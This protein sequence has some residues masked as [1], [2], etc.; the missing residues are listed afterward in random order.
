MMSPRAAWKPA[1]SAAALPKLRRKRMP[2]TSACCA[3]QLGDDLPGAVRAAV[4]HEDDFQIELLL[5]GHSGDLGVQRR[6][7]VALVED[8]NDDRN[9]DISSEGFLG[10]REY[11]LL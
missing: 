11:R 8:R 1:D 5:R 10:A 4:V 9:H 7:A 6:Q 3:G 2:W